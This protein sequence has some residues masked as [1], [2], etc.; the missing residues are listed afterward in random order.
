MGGTPGTDYRIRPPTAF[1]LLICRSEDSRGP[2]Q[3]YYECMSRS[4]DGKYLLCDAPECSAQTSAP[5]ALNPVTAD[6]EDGPTSP[7]R[8]LFVQRN[9]LWRHFCPDHCVHELTNPSSR[10]KEHIV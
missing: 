7:V 10:V 5:V 4:P 2:P 1:Y 8:W 6:A 3:A 9:G